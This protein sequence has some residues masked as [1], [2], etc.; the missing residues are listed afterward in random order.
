[1]ASNPPVSRIALHGAGEARAVDDQALV[2]RART[3]DADAREELARLYLADVYQAVIR[4]LPDRQLAEDAAQD[5]FVNALNA[6]DRFRG[7]SSFRT[8]LLRI[9]VNSARTV[10]RKQWRRKEVGLMVAGDAP[11][12]EPDPATATV[13]KDEARRVQTYVDRLPKKQRLAVTLR[14]NQGLNYAE[15]ASVLNCTEGAARVNYHLGIKR[16]R[17]LLA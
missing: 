11:S 3:G 9:A 7:D 6:L 12:R 10:A 5:A 16:L 4:V 13:L 8:W 1:V 17:E 2:D 15:I 14:V